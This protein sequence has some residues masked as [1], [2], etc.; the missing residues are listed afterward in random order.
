ME[1][2]KLTKRP[3][4]MEQTSVRVPTADKELLYVAARREGVS[5]SEFLR[6]AIRE[7]SRRVLLEDSQE[8]DE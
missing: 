6:L 4:V 8:T 1:Q 7:R 3:A 2:R 5:Q